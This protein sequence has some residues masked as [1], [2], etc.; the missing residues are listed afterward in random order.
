MVPAG[1]KRIFGAW[2]AA[3]AF[4]AVPASASAAITSVFGGQ[5]I[6]GGAIPCTAGTDGVRSCHGA[7]G[8]GGSAD[9]RLRSFDGSPLEVYVILPPAPSSG[10]DGPYPL[11]VQSHGWGGSAGGPNATAYSGPTADAWAKQGFAVL[12][13]TARGFG[14]SCCP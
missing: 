1:M 6:A 9:L 7:D 14:D 8:G 3:V 10:P 5:T 2:A 13:L 12:Q 4:L 11:I